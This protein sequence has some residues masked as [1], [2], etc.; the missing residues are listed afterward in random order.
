MSDG[1]NF[2]LKVGHSKDILRPLH[3]HQQTNSPL[4]IHGE[5]VFLFGVE[6]DKCDRIP[7]ESLLKVMLTEFGFS[8]S[9]VY[10]SER[11][12]TETF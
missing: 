8:R 1:P 5:V 12:S 11:R 3:E 7:A 10:N 6:T 4:R 2:I 9:T